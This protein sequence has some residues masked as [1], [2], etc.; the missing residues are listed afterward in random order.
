M[1]F[2]NYFFLYPPEPPKIVLPLKFMINTKFPCFCLSLHCG[3]NKKYKKHVTYIQT[4]LGYVL[5][6]E[7]YNCLYVRV[8]LL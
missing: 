3:N 8:I 2:F 4:Q 5:V 7:K 6:I 1:F